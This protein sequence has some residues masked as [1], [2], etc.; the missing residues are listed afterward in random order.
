MHENNFEKQVQEKM[1]QLG[2]DPSDAVW[3]AVD[4]EIN[5]DKKRRRPFFI[6]FFFSGLLLA[7]GGI[8][9]GMI[10]NSKAKIVTSQQQKEKK[11]TQ[12]EQSDAKVQ[13]NDSQETLLNRESVNS[14]VL[15]T[16]KNLKWNQ[17]KEALLTKSG[18]GNTIPDNT[19]DI[20]DAEN[21]RPEKNTIV[22]RNGKENI[23]EKNPARN[24]TETDK[25]STNIDSSL[26]K[27]MTVAENKT[28]KDSVSENKIAKINNQ[29]AKSSKWK[30]GFTGGAGISNINQSL[31]QPANITGLYYSPANVNIG[32][33]AAPPPV[34]VS[35]QIN[36]GFSFGTGVFVCRYLSKR[37]SISAGLNYHYYSTHVNTGYA[38]DSSIVVYY[39][40]LSSGT[41]TLP[42]AYAINGYYRNG[43]NY[44]YTNSYHFIELPLTADF[45]LNKSIKLPV[46]WEAG[47]SVSYLINSNALHFDPN[48]N[49]YYQNAELFNKIQLNGT[50]A[51][52]IGFPINKTELQVGPQL[53]YGLTGLLKTGSG[54]PQ[55]LFYTGLKISFILGKK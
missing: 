9:F 4:K 34:P 1:D 20:N 3:T 6:L 48:G 47:L 44:S 37:I 54:N 28:E 8:Y 23:K 38:V 26:N 27:P 46:F 18:I 21:N 16:A 31:F 32:N 13:N 24:K 35:S 51:F 41:S 12:V 42:G 22:L 7:G 19:K 52:M 30:F 36:P 15:K 45:Q 29:K 25:S 53:Q 49:L 10:K 5:K 39:P 55:H 14:K 43:S 11:E 2:F 33:G 17:S 40:G 50:T